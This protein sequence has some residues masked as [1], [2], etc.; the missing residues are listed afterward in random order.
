MNLAP[1]Y[2]QWREAT[3]QEALQEG[4]QAGLQQGQR[5]VIENL[6]R[7]RF[8]AVDE[9]LSRVIDALLQL[10][11]AEYTRLCVELSREELLARFS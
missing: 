8:G 11:P 2:L 9:E 1:A 10:P 3:R 7:V 6:L 5:V 4:I